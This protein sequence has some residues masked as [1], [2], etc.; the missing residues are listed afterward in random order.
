MIS[1]CKTTTTQYRL[2]LT[3]EEV[4]ELIIQAVASLKYWPPGVEPKLM[5]GGDRYAGC[6]LSMTFYG[7][8]KTDETP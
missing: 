6:D 4:V 2:E 5:Y 1:I 7:E 3:H 8:K